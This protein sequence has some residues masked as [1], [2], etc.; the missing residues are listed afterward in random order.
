MHTE[1]KNIFDDKN[2]GL[3]FMSDEQTKRK[4]GKEVLKE[5][6]K[7][8]LKYEQED[9]GATASNGCLYHFSDGDNPQIGWRIDWESLYNGREWTTD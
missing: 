8:H 9:I 3:T 6:K 1:W 4:A 5:A 2:D 7:I